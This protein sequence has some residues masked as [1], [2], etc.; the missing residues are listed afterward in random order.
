MNV[1]LMIIEIQFRLKIKYINQ[2]LSNKDSIAM[3]Q[4]L[5]YKDI[6][7]KYDDLRHSIESWIIK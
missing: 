7:L 6:R 2:K 3:S 4:G 1:K 5:I